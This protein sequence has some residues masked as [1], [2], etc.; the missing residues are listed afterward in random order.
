MYVGVLLAAGFS[1]RFGHEDKLMQPVNGEMAMALVAARSL[2]AVLE[3]AVAVVRQENT[4]L[5]A[6]L[7]E[8]GFHVVC[9]EA[10]ATAMSDSLIAGVDAAVHA[11]PAMQGLLV[12]LA[13][14]PMIQAETIQKVVECLQRGACIVQPE[15]A[16][17]PGHPVGFDVQMVAELLAV[18]G[19]Q[20]ARQVLKKHAAA[21][22]R[23]RCDDAGIVLD[24]DTPAQLAQ[25]QSSHR[26]G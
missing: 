5:A 26:T 7:H 18:R 9:C 4:A 21:V 2:I 8:M 13:D 23:L 6:A 20:G 12:A 25:L 1:R 19:D 15:Y 3:Q 22:T 14:M 11:F 10:Q 16:Q 17:Q 24:I